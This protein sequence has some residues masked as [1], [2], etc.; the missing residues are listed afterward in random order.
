MGLRSYTRAFNGGEVAPAMFARIDDAKYQTGLAKCKN[1]LIEPQGPLVNRPGFEYVRETKYA[2]KKA[3]LIPFSF[4]D[5][6]TMVLEFGE[7]YIRFHTNGATLL[8]DDGSIYEIESPYLEDDLRDLHYVQSSD[9]L[10]IVHPSHAPRELRRYSALDWRLV[11]ISF[12]STLVAPNNVRAEQTIN[13]EV[14]NKTDYTREYAVTSLLADGSQESVRSTSASVSC[15]PYGDG[16]FNTVSWDAVAGAGL[17]RVYR[18]Q[19]GIWAYIGQT[20]DTKI[21]DENIDPDASITPPLYDDAFNQTSG[22]ASVTISS[23]GAGYQDATTTITSQDL[24]NAKVDSRWFDNGDGKWRYDYQGK[25]YNSISWPMYVSLTIG[26]SYNF[27]C[28]VVDEGGNGSGAV[29]E[30]ILRSTPASVGVDWWLDGF[31][32]TKVG[33]NYVKP[34]AYCYAE[35]GKAYYGEKWVKRWVIPLTMRYDAIKH[36]VRAQDATGTGFDAYALSTNGK[37]TQ[38]VIR[39]PGT[40][41]SEPTLSI[42]SS[43]TTKATLTTNV[44]A[45]GDYPGAVS[46]FEQR[47]WFGGTL[48][49]P[50]HLWATKSGTESVM[51]YSLPTQDT[52]RIAVRVAARES[53]RIQHIVPLAHLMLLTGSA[54][55][56]VSPL[57]DD[58]IT[59][60]SMS[61]RPQSYVGANNVQPLVIN[62]TMIYVANRGGHLRECGYNYQAGGFV[63]NDICLRAPHLFDNLD[64]VDMAFAK[65]PWPIA[66]AVSSNGN[67]IALTY[68]PEQ[69]V[70]AFSTVETKGLFKACC[71]VAESDE[72]I[73]YCIVERT[74]NGQTKQFV[75]RMHERQFKKLEDCIYMDCAGTYKGPAKQEITGLNWLEGETVSILAD[76]SVEPNQVVTNGK[77]TLQQPASLVHIGLPYECD[78]KTLPVALALQDGSYGSGHKKNV[79]KVFFRVVNSSGLKSGPSFDELTS[80]APRSIELA[81]NP[82]DPITDEFGF[83]ISAAWSNGGQVCVRQDH[84]LPMR[85]VSMTVDLE[86]A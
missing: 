51:A 47:R 70:G 46:Y 85:V 58:A 28:E 84:P 21:V 57:N 59:P 53:S 69:Q 73:L 38:V 55:W 41:Y 86:V 67:L 11:V 74:I 14:T 13:G 31:K 5:T 18:N 64:V 82:P 63:S 61:V 15:N 8:R 12:G 6:Q 45:V 79:R 10:T 7:K 35:T 83:V 81:G 71:V 54:E 37:I 80:Y 62:N 50:N 16:A 9:I 39:N 3:V 78:M 32:I 72:D 65:A 27:R 36:E 25:A 34:V 44:K 1:F 52:D 43:S 75:E 56:R 48:N 40:G 42:A 68:V 49:R 66:W 23:A 2:N 17:Y 33:S 19:G 76:G 77:I 29:I 60:S 20:S 22:I 24:A 4:S 30:P 26:Y